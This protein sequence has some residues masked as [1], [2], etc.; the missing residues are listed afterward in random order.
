MPPKAATCSP[1]QIDSIL[2]ARK[3]RKTGEIQYLIRWT[4]FPPWANSWQNE[5]D[6]GHIMVKIYT[7]KFTAK[8]MH[9]MEKIRAQDEAQAQAQAQVQDQGDN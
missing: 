4:D 8:G 6:L 9:A 1:W 7:F 5:S 3:D 2:D